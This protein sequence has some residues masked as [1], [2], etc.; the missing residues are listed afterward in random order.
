M[1][2][3]PEKLTITALE[4]IDDLCAEFE[5]R[6]QS[7]QPQ[8]IESVLAAE[9]SDPERE[10]LFSELLA[11]EIDYRKR[12]GDPPTA[13][14]YVDRFPK[15]AKT[16]RDAFHRNTGTNKL[17]EPPS[18][19]RISELFP[20][21]EVESLLGAGGMGAVYKARQKGLD[22]PI[23]L[24][25][26]PEEFDHD[27]KFALRFTREA[28]TL[29]KLNHPNI[30]SVHEFGTVENIYYFMMEYVDGPTLRDVVRDKQL[31]PEHAL[32]IVP[33]LCDA[34]QFAHDQGIVHRDI[35]PENI[36]MGRDGA[37]KIADF[38]LSRIMGNDNQQLTLTQTNQILGTPRY[39]APE[40]FD[41]SHNVDHRADIY[42][43]GVVF[44]EMLTGEI[45][46]GRFEAPS[47]KVQ[48]DLRLDE[49]VLRTLEQEPVRRYQ[50]ASELKTALDSISATPDKNLAA[51][52][53]TG[54]QSDVGLN[55]PFTRTSATDLNQQETAARLLLSRQEL[56]GRIKLALQPL[57]RG[58][59]IQI[60]FGVALIVL[61]AQ[62][63]AQNTDIPHRLIC[64]IVLHIYGVVVI[65]AG[66]HV[67][68]RIRRIDYSQATRNIRERLEHVRSAQLIEGPIVGFPWWLMWIPVSVAFGFDQVMHPS[69]LWVSLAVGIFGFGISLWLHR[70]FT[71][72]TKDGENANSRWRAQIVGASLHSAHKT[73]C[74][75]ENASID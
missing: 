37:V 28:R 35:K 9:F 59:L 42:S 24:K 4:R 17:F 68:T 57:R 40:Q 50:A 36:L 10:L 7:T 26:L 53:A 72:Q 73:L 67:L 65:G 25:I 20:S 61:G 41:G 32:A 5:R 60:L 11:L 43:L 46:A 39:M 51:T 49:V 44:Y 34:L 58:M 12:N 55:S 74:E 6:W 13:S 64:G 33:K 18:L 27:V 52:I 15:N 71:N 8:S 29:A 48:L 54:T 14:E 3:H 23:A 31:K 38:G 75:I 62:C 47:H 21:L 1:T 30:V 16:V 2:N 22:R 45:P 63:W 70:R 69:A 66:A 56:M 19:D